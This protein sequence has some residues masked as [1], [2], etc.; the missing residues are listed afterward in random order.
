MRE[1]PRFQDSIDLVALPAA[2]TVA[3]LFVADILRR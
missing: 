2:V 1:R 3:R